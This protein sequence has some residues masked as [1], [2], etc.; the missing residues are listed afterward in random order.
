MLPLP[1]GW[2]TDGSSVLV[3]LMDRQTRKCEILRISTDGKQVTQINVPHENFY[4]Y[5]ALSPDG[6]LIIYA[7]ME[8]RYLGLYI[9]PV[10]GG[11]S[12]PLAVTENNHN[13]GAA[14]SPDGKF[15]AFTSTRSGNFDIW[16]MEVD[17]ER[18]KD[19]LED[20]EE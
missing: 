18:I 2:W 1:G 8:G 5:L 20:T 4:R 7:A 6:T 11:K 13:E 17:I 10:A 15:I 12:L 19:E 16:I 9:M 3:A 14:W